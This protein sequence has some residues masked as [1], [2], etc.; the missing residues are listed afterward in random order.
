MVYQNA[1]AVT[2][3]LGFLGL[4]LGMLTL[5]SGVFYLSSNHQ[6]QDPADIS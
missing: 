6:P 4:I 5:I 2:T 1:F 3:G